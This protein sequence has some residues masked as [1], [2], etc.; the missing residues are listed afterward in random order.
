MSW[1]TKGDFNSDTVHND[2]WVFE[3]GGFVGIRKSVCNESTGYG[4]ADD[5][6]WDTPSSH[7]DVCS[8][9][10]N[11]DLCGADPGESG[12]GVDE[13]ERIIREL[14]TMPADEFYSLA[15]DPNKIRNQNLA[16]LSWSN[17]GCSNSPDGMG[18][19]SFLGPCAR[20]DF[21]Y[22][23][24]HA[25]EDY[26]GED[27]FSHDAKIAAD[28]RLEAGIRE[29]CDASCDWAAAIYGWAVRNFGT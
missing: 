17:D 18:G 14:E 26:T 5:P 4:C 8:T 16:W 25:W 21:S 12:L 3:V 2:D 29:V 7:T 1:K 24:G 11:S 15:R 13:E 27:F 28:D 6:V 9:P 23:N 19:T 10:G 22:R 20:H